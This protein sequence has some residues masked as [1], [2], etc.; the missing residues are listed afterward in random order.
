MTVVI[1]SISQYQCIFPRSVP[2]S[3]HKRPCRNRLSQDP[4][5]RSLFW[6]LSQTTELQ[7]LNLK[8]HKKWLAI[9]KVSRTRQS[10]PQS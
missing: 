8:D 10:H 9:E 3:L 4:L 5:V 2:T 6:K 7:Q 1:T